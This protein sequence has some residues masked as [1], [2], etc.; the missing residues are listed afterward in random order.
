M[1]SKSGA[2][3]QA[4]KTL[5]L[6]SMSVISESRIASVCPSDVCHTFEH[7]CA[8]NTGYESR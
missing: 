7:V 4:G 2:S 1:N 6:K 5:P 8:Q 3:N